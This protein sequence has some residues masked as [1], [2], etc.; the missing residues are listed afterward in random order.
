MKAIKISLF[1]ITFFI[2]SLLHSQV[3]KRVEPPFWWTGMNNPKLQLML[4]G[5]NLSKLSPEI[6]YEGVKIKQITQLENPNYL[7]IDLILDDDVVAG[8]FDIR[9]FDRNT[10]VAK[11]IYELKARTKNSAIRKGFDQS[12]VLYLI[13]PDRFVNGNPSNDEI[14]GMKEKLN[15]SFKFGRHGGDIEGI[16]QSLDYVKDL[17][18]TA[19]WM[20]PLLENDMI[21]SSY[22]GY[23]TTDF[24][25]VDPRFGTNEKY[26]ALVNKAH[27]KGLK[28]IMD[29]IVNHCG[30][31]HWWMKDA[32]SSD[33]FNYQKESFEGN[34]QNT[35]HRKT[36]IQDP[37]AAKIDIKEMTEGW[38]VKVMPDMNQK[39]QYMA[40][41]LIQNTIWWIEYL[42]IDGIR[43]DTYPYPGKEFMKEW[44]CAVQNEYPYF[45]VVAE[46]W[47]ENPAIL[48]HWQQ[49]KENSNGYTSCLPSLMDFPLQV[50]VTKSLNSKEDTWWSGWLLTYETIGLDF[51]Y[52]NYDNLVVFPD[53]HDM[54]RFY[55]QV[56]ENFE[57]FKLGI[58]LYSTMRGIPQFYYGTEILM[59]NIKARNDHGII[60]S[61]FPGGWNGDKVNAFTQRGLSEKQKEAQDFFKRL[62]QW[63]KSQNT[64]HYGKF[65][66][67]NPSNGVYV[68]FRYD[69]KDKVMIILNKNKKN[70]TLELARFKE[71]IQGTET[72]KDIISGKNIALNGKNLTVPAITPMV[73]DFD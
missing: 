9:L 4:Y 6:D 31:E 61:D 26:R 55:T 39:N 30:S 64:I 63:R 3:L 46:E 15:R 12:D 16:I 24:Y 66:H 68:Y 21:E 53:N 41:Y 70:I 7:V 47:Y 45:N 69:D 58:A 67:F 32:P 49:D 36:T 44:T 13:T 25:Q 59:S 33:W 2:T 28:I 54:D 65:L 73:I 51:L 50:K 72:G 18:F 38:F 27:N 40:I 57:L 43:M 10:E 11:Y 42:G 52:A 23:A 29:M 60:R 14:E 5:K 19:V 22:H 71:M 56:E 1:S 8:T 20:N 34:Y 62:L 37:H 17:G 48:A 35:N